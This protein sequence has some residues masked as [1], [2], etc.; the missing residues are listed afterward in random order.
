LEKEV[1]AERWT[2]LDRALRAAADEGGGIADLRPS[3]PGEDPKLRRLMVGRAAKLERLGLADQVSP[4]CWTFKPSIEQT[5]RDLSIRGD[6]IKTMH[7]ALVSAGREP[8]V[9][10]FALHGD[11]VTDQVLGR[12]VERGLLNELRGSAYAIV[13]G[14]DGRPH[15][16]QFSTL[17]MTGDAKVGA[18]VEARA[19]Q[20]DKGHD[21][22]SLAVR[23]DLT[24][25]EQVAAPGATW[26]DRQLL[27]RDAASGSGFGVE[28]QEAMDRRIEHL[29]AE[30]LVRRQGQ[31]TVFAGDLLGTLRRREL[32]Q[33]ASKL[34]AES[35][36]SFTPASDGDHVAGVY[37]R[38]VILSSG[39][40]AMIDDGLGFQLVPW[41]PALEPH[42]NEH[43][44][45][46]VLPG[47]RVDWS[48]GRKRGLSL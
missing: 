33:V 47:G 34:S 17:E 15:Y 36:L 38:R 37:R 31:Q 28:V 30:R 46:M 8:D 27:S 45:G 2:G 21:R 32:D 22:L 26:L 9:S 40:F 35:G 42:A 24:L 44:A 25:Q 48:F 19:Y 3:P 11:R 1:A 14:I 18:I 5:L 23:S 10:G 39:R 7:R 13:D 6:I 4:G 16:L 43:V 20:D 29:I 41:R 12:L